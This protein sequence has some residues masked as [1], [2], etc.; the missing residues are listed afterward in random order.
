LDADASRVESAE[1]VITRAGI[2]DFRK[3]HRV[4]RGLQ[5]RN[6]AVNARW[7]RRALNNSTLNVLRDQEAAAAIRALLQRLHC[8]RTY[9]PVMSSPDVGFK[10]IPIVFCRNGFLLGWRNAGCT[11]FVDH[12]E[13]KSALRSD[14]A[15]LD[16][17]FTGWRT[18]WKHHRLSDR[19]LLQ[20]FHA[21]L[22]LVRGLLKFLCS[23]NV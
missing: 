22:I 14:F 21:D 4:T 2:I 10:R 15:A 16:Y 3:D 7:R 8:A 5:A 12:G 20:S 11:F 18:A 17:G 19:C 6:H 1:R 23:L 13:I 9:L